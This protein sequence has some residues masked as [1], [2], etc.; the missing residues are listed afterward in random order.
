MKVSVEDFGKMKARTKQL[1]DEFEPFRKKAVEIQAH[2]SPWR[3]RL[4]SGDSD[5]E[6]RGALYNDKSIHNTA[7]LE[8]VDIA[9]AGIKSGISP[10]SR[11]WFKIGDHDPDISERAGPAAW[12]NGVERV[13]N[14]IFHRSNT[15]DSLHELYAEKV[16]WGDGNSMVLPSLKTVSR[17]RPFTYGEIRVGVD[18]E[19]DVNAFT[20]IFK[21]NVGQIVAQFGVDM[22]PPKLLAEYKRGN[23]EGRH[24]VRLLVEPNDDRLK[25][26]DALGRPVRSMYWLEGGNEDEIL[27]V[28]GFDLFPLINGSWHKVAGQRYGIGLG[29]RNLR[30]CKRFQKLEERSLLQLDQNSMPSFRKSAANAQELIDAGPWGVTVDNDL[31]GTPGI[32]PLFDAKMN[33]KDLEYKIERAERA[34]RDGFYN[35]IFMMI[36]NST[37]ETD[38]AFEVARLMEEKYS[39]LGPVIERSQHMLGQLIQLNFH[40]AYEAGLIPEPPQELQ[41]RELKIEYISI[42]AQ[43]QKMAGLKGLTDTAMFASDLAARG[44]PQALHKIDPLQ[45]VDEFARINSVTPAIVRSDEQVDDMMAAEQEA[46]ARKQAMEENVA[47]AGAAKDISDVE[48]GGRSAMDVLT[49]GGQ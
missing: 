27:G 1:D 39:V 26:K 22:L 43:A 34:I 31:S 12:F 38:T 24:K 45:A 36:A 46:L 9:A 37:S 2:V 7:V 25:V 16:T 47:M 33:T 23:L 5:D 10:A 3:G 18:E 20:R 4:L 41:G 6:D 14:Q 8:A 11:P 17:M 49:G 30:N 44:W 15:Y 35:N 29:H 48:L 28:T 19:G 32:T 42:L 21:M 13:L 40:Y